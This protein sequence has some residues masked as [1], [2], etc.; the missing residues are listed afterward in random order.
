MTPARLL[1][2][3]ALTAST[4][5]VA[6]A[7]RVRSEPVHLRADRIEIDQ[8]KGVSRYLGNVDLRQGALHVTAARAE[9]RSRGD[10]LEFVTA[11]GAPL[12]F[13]DQP[14]GMD[15]PIEG[16]A[17]RL[18]YEALER[19]VHLYGNVE[20]RRGDDRIRADSLHYD[21]AADRAEAEGGERTRVYTTVTPRRQ[22]EP[23]R[24][25]KP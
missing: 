11:E 18:E 15:R 17:Q 21:I 3:A 24:E 1:L 22:D 14:A 19:R 2:V 16:V 9:A 7:E 8:K 12:T 4:L 13:R 20:I 10:T 5:P 6:A 25:P 23:P